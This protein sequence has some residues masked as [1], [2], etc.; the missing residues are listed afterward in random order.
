MTKLQKAEKKVLKM[1]NLYNSATNMTDSEY[2]KELWQLAKLQ[3]KKLKGVKTT[4]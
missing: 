3:Y 1:K 2:Y 4:L